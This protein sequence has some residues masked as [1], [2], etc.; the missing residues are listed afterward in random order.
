MPSHGFNPNGPLTMLSHGESCRIL[1]QCYYAENPGSAR[2]V[3]GCD[4]NVPA[5][6]SGSRNNKTRPAWVRFIPYGLM[7]VAFVAAM[8]WICIYGH[9]WAVSHEPVESGLFDDYVELLLRVLRGDT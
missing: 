6:L 2:C 7:A 3:V 9:V 4:D 8:G 5:M 1:D